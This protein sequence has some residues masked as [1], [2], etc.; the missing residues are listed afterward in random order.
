MRCP[1]VGNSHRR[2]VKAKVP[3]PADYFIFP[4]AVLNVNLGAARY[5]LTTDALLVK[6]FLV[7]PES[8]MTVVLF[9]S[10]HLQSS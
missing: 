7:T 10:A 3:I 4:I 2:W 5:M 6:Y 8:T 9:R 1:L